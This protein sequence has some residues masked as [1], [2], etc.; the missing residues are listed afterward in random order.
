MHVYFHRE[1]KEDV[2]FITDPLVLHCWPL[3][4][5]PVDFAGLFSLRGILWMVLKLG[6]ISLSHPQKTHSAEKKLRSQ[7]RRQP[8]LRSD[9][10]IN[11]KALYHRVKE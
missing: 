4:P 11:K 6:N 3:M 10:E 2:V 9:E 5:D 8:D 1:G 7:E